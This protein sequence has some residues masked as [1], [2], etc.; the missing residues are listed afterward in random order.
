MGIAAARH[1]EPHH[2]PVGVHGVDGVVAGAAA[3]GRGHVEYLP[4]H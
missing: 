1:V 4:T 3:V 2:Q